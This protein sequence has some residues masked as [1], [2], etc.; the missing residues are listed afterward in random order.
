MIA[1]MPSVLVG[2]ATTQARCASEL[3]FLLRAGPLLTC[4]QFL[5]DDFP[6]VGAVD[7]R[8]ANVLEVVAALPRIELLRSDA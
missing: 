3:L 8:P 5:L 6:H 7:R 2:N 1:L 4:A